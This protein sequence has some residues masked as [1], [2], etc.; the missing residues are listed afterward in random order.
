M[1]SIESGGQRA[2]YL[3]D[4]VPTTAH[5]AAN[6]IMGIDL[7]PVDTLSEKQ[8]ILT[9]AADARTM[10]FF[11]HDPTIAAGSI[12]VEDGRFRVIPS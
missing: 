9:E 8:A 4:L 3:G 5:L 10:L 1:V 2:F 7:Y 12:V 11:Y 6:W